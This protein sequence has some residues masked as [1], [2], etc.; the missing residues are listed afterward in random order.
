LVSHRIHCDSIYG[1]NIN[2]LERR[3]PMDLQLSGKRAVVTGSSSGI[4]EAIAK[5][6][7]AEG[8]AVVVHGRRAD[9]A[10]RVAEEIAAAGGKAVVA[11]GD[12]SSDAGADAVAKVVNDTLGG[13]DILVNNAGAFPHTPWLESTAADWNDLYNQ[14]VG[15]MVRMTTRFVPGMK[16]RGWGRVISLASVV[17]TM[18]FPTGAAYA[19]TKS[20]GANLAVSL[21]K[22]LTG[23]GVTSNAVSPGM[24]VTPGVE[25]MLKEMAPQ[26]GLPPDDLPALEQFAAE[27]MVHNPSARLGRPEDIAAAVTFLASPLAGYINGANLRVDGGTVPT[28]N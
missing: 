18:P 14:N 23:T 20:A 25:S 22:E 5:S 4:G 24:I 6:L 13:V 1:K 8:V 21:A 17:A 26:F 19:A 27:K 15:S 28:V 12:L 3:S 9:Q 16:Q 2:I 11:V 10:K 7:A